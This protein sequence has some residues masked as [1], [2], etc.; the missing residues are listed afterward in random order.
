[1]T[2]SWNDPYKSFVKK[3]INR[4]RNIWQGWV[5]GARYLQ[6]F[7]LSTWRPPWRPM[8]FAPMAA[9][10]KVERGYHNPSKTISFWPVFRM[11]FSWNDPLGKRKDHR[12]NHST[13]VNRVPVTSWLVD[14]IEPIGSRCVQFST[15]R[16]DGTRNLLIN[17]GNLAYCPSVFDPSSHPPYT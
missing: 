16:D 3:L 2:F 14:K 7:C 6:T 8:S 4:H 1:M 12:S 15:N 13:G 9:R 11:T 10:S 5:H 17:L